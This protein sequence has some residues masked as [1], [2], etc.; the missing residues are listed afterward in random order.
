MKYRPSDFVLETLGNKIPKQ[1]LDTVVDEWDK[2]VE[3]Y[4]ILLVMADQS[5]IDAKFVFFYGGFLTGVIKAAEANNWN[6][7]YTNPM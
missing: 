2:K 5:A 6:G 4:K 1:L 3:L 7:R